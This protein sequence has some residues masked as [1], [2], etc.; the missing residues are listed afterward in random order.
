MFLNPS[1]NPHVQIIRAFG[2]AGNIKPN[3]VRIAV[4]TVVPEVKFSL[5]SA[6]SIDE[7]NRNI[8]SAIEVGLQGLELYRN[9]IA[10]RVWREGERP[11]TTIGAVVF[12]TVN[13]TIRAAIGAGR[14]M[15]ALLTFAVAPWITTILATLT[16]VLTTIRATFTWVLIA[17]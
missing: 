11:F 2:Q 13:T 7:L 15:W 8:S 5:S 14:I 1:A 4:A 9:H 17:T 16:W 12:F 3:R 10:N 6:G